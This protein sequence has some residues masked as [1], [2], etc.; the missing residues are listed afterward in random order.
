MKIKLLPQWAPLVSRELLFFT[1]GATI[2]ASR[3]PRVGIGTLK[4]PVSQNRRERKRRERERVRERE[5]TF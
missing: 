3:E 1:D 5:P 4:E 2:G